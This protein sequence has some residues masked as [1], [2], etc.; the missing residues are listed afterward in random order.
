MMP[1]VGPYLAMTALPGTLEPLRGRA[2]EVY[3]TGWRP[4]YGEG[5]DRAGLV[6][7]LRHAVT[8]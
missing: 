7:A 8:A 5:P 1:L 3:T 4:P 6:A 2:R